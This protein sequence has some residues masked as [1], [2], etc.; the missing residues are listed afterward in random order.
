MKTSHTMGNLWILQQC[1]PCP[2]DL[3]RSP[4][5]DGAAREKANRPNISPQKRRAPSDDSSTFFVGP[6]SKEVQEA[7]HAK[8]SSG[9]DWE[10]QCSVREP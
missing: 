1:S 6:L 2:L 7:A 9:G 8:E 3:V 10:R 4:Q 5:Q